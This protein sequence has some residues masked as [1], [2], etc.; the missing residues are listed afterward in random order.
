MSRKNRE[1]V[2]EGIQQ[3]VA[4]FCV[5]QRVSDDTGWAKVTDTDID[6]LSDIIQDLIIIKCERDV[7]GDLSVEFDLINRRKFRRILYFNKVRYSYSHGQKMTDPA[8]PIQTLAKAVET[9]SEQLSCA[10]RVLGEE[11]RTK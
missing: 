3:K 10:I 5:D 1:D 11:E 9:A 7:D 6:N 2:L 4:D 8:H